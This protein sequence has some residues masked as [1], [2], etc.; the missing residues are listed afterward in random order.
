LAA[1]QSV[2]VYK[3]PAPLAAS[4]QGRT[5][6]KPYSKE[7][8]PYSQVADAADAASPYRTYLVLQITTVACNPSLYLTL[9]YRLLYNI[10]A[11]TGTNC[12][13]GGCAHAAYPTDNPSTVASAAAN[14][15]VQHHFVDTSSEWY[16]SISPTRPPTLPG[17]P[18]PP[19]WPPPPPLVRVIRMTTAFRVLIDS[20]RLVSCMVI[21][22]HRIR[23][24]AL[25]AGARTYKWKTVPA[26]TVPRAGP[27]S[28]VGPPWC[29]HVLLLAMPCCAYPMRTTVYRY[30]HMCTICT[31]NSVS[32][33][34]RRR[35]II[36][37]SNQHSVQK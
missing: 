24:E 3:V 20:N 16:N 10:N 37:F 1:H 34:A 25:C 13:V 30:V 11:I 33:H 6:E 27:I 29:F 23:E 5:Q 14:V 28:F 17:D 21:C 4:H 36:L 12:G 2:R 19:P 15:P 35:V 9:S 7:A 8:L 31:I 32:I 18:T 26:T 22:G